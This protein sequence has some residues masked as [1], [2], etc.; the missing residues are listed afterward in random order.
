MSSRSVAVTLTLIAILVTLA[1]FAI[2][3]LGILTGEPQSRPTELA[4]LSG[5]IP[6]TEPPIIG[7]ESGIEIK[8]G[9]LI[10]TPEPTATPEP[11]PTREPTAW[12]GHRHQIGAGHD[13][14]AAEAPQL[15]LSDLM[16]RLD[17]DSVGIVL[18][19]GASFI[20]FPMTS[21]Y[22]TA[23]TYVHNASPS[24]ISRQGTVIGEA[25]STAMVGFSDQ[26]VSQRVIVIMTD[27]E[28]HEG[29]PVAA[30]RQAAKDG[31]VTYTVGFGS[32]D[33]VPVPE[34]DERGQ[35]TGSARDSQGR[36]VISQLDEVTL[37]SVA[38]AGGGRYFRASE[39]D[40]MASLAGE[41]R[42]YQDEAFQ[43]EF[44]QRKVERLQ[45]FLLAGAFSLVLAE[46]ATDRLSLWYRRRRMWAAE[47]AAHV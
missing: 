18:F 10:P 27:G 38:E 30:A 47:G 32:P 15:E 8:L 36:T 40:A 25:I 17:G 28:S 26:R 23:R 43:S 33:G 12:H 37:R 46:L 29:D 4:N 35:I 20:Q 7:D 3:A 42:S 5:P 14:R 2:L 21:D 45:V 41:I 9:K 6:T 24:A 13:I 11:T 19:S 22:A 16:S 39:I 44:S 31:A 34:Y 1:L